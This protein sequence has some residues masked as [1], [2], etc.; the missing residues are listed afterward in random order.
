[1]K[2][3]EIEEIKY[4]VRWP[5]IVTD[6]VREYAKRMAMTQ[7]EALKSMVIFHASRSKKQI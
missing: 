1:M 7:S 6:Y 5:K 4:H 2:N 3:K